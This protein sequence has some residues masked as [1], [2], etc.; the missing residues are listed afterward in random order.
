[1]AQYSI[2]QRYTCNIRE[3]IQGR[4]NR[5]YAPYSDEKYH[6]VMDVSAWLIRYEIENTLCDC[7]RI[8]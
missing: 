7:R 5:T 8:V 1:M 4:F 2:E 3:I 6:L